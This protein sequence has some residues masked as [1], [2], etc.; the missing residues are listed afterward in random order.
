MITIDL[1]DQAFTTQIQALAVQLRNPNAL[2]KVL[3][4]EAAKHLKGHF[5]KKDKAQ[6]NHLSPR[7]RHFW[8]EVASG[9]QNP[10]VNSDGSAV[11]VSISHPAI[12]Q[13]IR[14]GTIRAKRTRMLAIPVSEQAYARVPS[15][16]E[17]ETGLKLIFVR[18][19][20]RGG[21]PFSAAVLAT[22]R[23][24]GLQV[25]Y[26]LKASVTQKPDPTALPPKADLQAAIVKRATAYVA[27]T[28]NP[29][30]P[31]A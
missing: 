26:V 19:G 8:R 30:P 16:F 25:E 7:R 17:S 4:Q 9:V 15:I 20:G 27:R 2:T 3:G 5:R 14:G 22:R 13:K 12:A 21:N 29:Q 31:T 24:T 1:N 18:T 28:N 23:G 11:V 6:P 10:T